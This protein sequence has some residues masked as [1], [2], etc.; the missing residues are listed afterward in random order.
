ML[1]RPEHA[2][3]RERM[4]ALPL[5]PFWGLFPILF[6]EMISTVSHSFQVAASTGCLAVWICLVH[7]SFSPGAPHAYNAGS[8]NSTGEDA[9][10][11]NSSAASASNAFKF[12]TDL[13]SLQFRQLL[14]HALPSVNVNIT[15][16]FIVLDFVIVYSILFYSILLLLCCR[17]VQ[18]NMAT[19]KASEK[20][21]NIISR[22]AT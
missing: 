1:A 11:K 9:S 17:G 8:Q 19:A 3:V 6:L 14:H 10:W 15:N 5:C 20:A 18:R 12:I 7:L 21:R 22:V 13:L 4:G 2:Q 16:I